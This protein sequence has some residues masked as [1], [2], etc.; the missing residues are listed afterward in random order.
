ML[1]NVYILSLTRDKATNTENALGV[2]GEQN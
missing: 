1:N 2:H